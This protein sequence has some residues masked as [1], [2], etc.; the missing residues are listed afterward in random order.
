[1]IPYRRASLQGTVCRNQQ[2][3]VLARAAASF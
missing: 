3:S 2:N 1:L